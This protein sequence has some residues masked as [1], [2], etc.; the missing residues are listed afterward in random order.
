MEGEGNLCIDF[1]LFSV[2]YKNV[3]P[4]CL[5]NSEWVLEQ[6]GD[7]WIYCALHPG[8]GYW[9]TGV[10]TQ[11]AKTYVILHPIEECGVIMAYNDDLLVKQ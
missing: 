7:D 2:S 8:T 1:V 9:G 5:L 6:G 3:L 4:K 11:T 10:I